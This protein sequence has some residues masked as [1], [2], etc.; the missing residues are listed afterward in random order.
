MD[1]FRR[2]FQKFAPRGL[3]TFAFPQVPASLQNP[4]YLKGYR[5]WVYA[6][7]KRKADSIATMELTFQRRQGDEWKEVSTGPALKALDLLHLRSADKADT[8]FSQP[9]TTP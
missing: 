3:F 8:K 9:V 7:V 2:L 6:C 1:L 4:D 5:G